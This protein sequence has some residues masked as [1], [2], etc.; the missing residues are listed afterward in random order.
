MSERLLPPS[1]PQNS[2]AFLEEL[3]A[4]YQRTIEYH[5]TEIELAKEKL[6][7]I[8]FLL[9]RDQLVPETLEAKS[10]IKSDLAE[11]E[12]NCDRP[13]EENHL[14]IDSS[15]KLEE[16]HQQKLDTELKAKENSTVVNS[17]T[18]QSSKALP[19]E[20]NNYSI[21]T[22]TPEQITSVIFSD[23]NSRENQAL[24]LTS[25]KND[26]LLIDRENIQESNQV[27]SLLT[28]KKIIENKQLEIRS[29]NDNVAVSLETEEKKIDKSEN[30]NSTEKSLEIE[31]LSFEEIAVKIKN[32]LQ[33]N[34]GTIVQIDYMIRKLW[35]KL[36]SQRIE[37]IKALLK[38][39]LIE[40]QKQRLWD[41]VPDAPNCWTIDLK[42]LP[43]YATPDPAQLKNLSVHSKGNVILG[44]IDLTL[45]EAAPKPLSSKEIAKILTPTKTS[46]KQKQYFF[47]RI[48]SLLPNWADKYGWH[49]LE[50]GVYSWGQDPNTI[51][52]NSSV[53]QEPITRSNGFKPL[54]HLPPTEKLD[55]YGTL[56][57]SITIF[58][59]DKAPNAVSAS[60]IL[61]WLYPEGLDRETRKKAYTSV[62]NCLSSYANFKWIRTKPGFY[63]WD[64]S[65]AA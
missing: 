65:L 30:Q 8:Q 15:E 23:L 56:I 62:S 29:V 52:E 39:H 44:A 1:A 3:E 42:L 61:N 51:E 57:K 54:K 43:D 10:H 47:K 36:E 60:D 32:I 14:K 28:D 20:A 40:G 12:K 21:I 41:K 35:G 24:N 4:Y 38:S 45:K 19:N 50:P 46:R 59:K 48:Q 37:T 64:E 26:S 27:N 9:D 58:I 6:G 16:Q 11:N 53:Q 49:K 22:S 34:P 17:Q 31:K 13:L 5:L 63:A 33:E 7:A 2:Q 18:N 55:R 25:K